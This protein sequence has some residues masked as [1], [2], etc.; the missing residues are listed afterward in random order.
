MS[1]SA[2]MSD[3]IHLFQL[4]SGTAAAEVEY[5]NNLFATARYN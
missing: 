1:V 5:T 3:H 4:P 2:S